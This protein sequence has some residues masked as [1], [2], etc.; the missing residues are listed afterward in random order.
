MPI[1]LPFCVY[2]HETTST[3][4]ICK[5]DD[6]APVEER[7][8]PANAN[9]AMHTADLN[10]LVTEPPVLPPDAAAALPPDPAA[11]LPP[12]PSDLNLN[13]LVT[14]TPVLPP[15][16]SAALPPN[17]AALLAP[18]PAE[19][20]MFPMEPPVLPPDPALL[21]DYTGPHGELGE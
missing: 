11:L 4:L 21:D 14:E 13:V 10:V 18:H 8:S 19:V 3:I 6:T 7:V 12:Y 9:A 17:P 20:N 5:A 16:P 2:L 1:D 15:N